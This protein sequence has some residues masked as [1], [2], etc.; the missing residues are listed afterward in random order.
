M[1]CDLSLFPKMKVK[2]KVNLFDTLEDVQCITDV[3][4]VRTGLPLSDLKIENSELLPKK[5]AL[6]GTSARFK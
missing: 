4:L 5:T 3:Q 6:K 1:S 2:F